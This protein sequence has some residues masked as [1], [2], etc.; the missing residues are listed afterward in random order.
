MAEFFAEVEKIQDTIRQTT[1]NAEAIWLKDFVAA[2]ATYTK[3]RC[4]LKEEFV[5]AIQCEEVGCVWTNSAEGTI[6][7]QLEP[8]VK[9]VLPMLGRGESSRQRLAL[10]NVAA[11]SI[12]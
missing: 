8:Y 2:V 10:E 5:V 12:I 3:E 4:R 6:T 7:T 11:D 1:E 9:S